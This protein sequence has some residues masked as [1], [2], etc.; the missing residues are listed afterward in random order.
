MLGGRVLQQTDGIIMGT[1]C[2]PPLAHLVARDRLHT[3]ASQT[4]RS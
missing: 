1:N 3:G 4:K 2:A